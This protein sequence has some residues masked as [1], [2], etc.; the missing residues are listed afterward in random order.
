MACPCGP[1]R[2]HGYHMRN[3]DRGTR[4]RSAFLPSGRRNRAM[5]YDVNGARL[6]VRESFPERLRN[7]TSLEMEVSSPLRPRR[8]KPIPGVADGI[9]ATRGLRTRRRGKPEDRQKLILLGAGISNCK[10][11][12]V[13]EKNGAWM[14]P[15]ACTLWECL[16]PAVTVAEQPAH[17]R[18]IRSVLTLLFCRMRYRT[19]ENDNANKTEKMRRVERLHSSQSAWKITP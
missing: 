17:R 4:A 7:L 15:R 1:H 10:S 3:G 9:S 18:C 19:M 11:K 6:K 2:P 12:L 16:S 13:K 5:V 14:A 8:R